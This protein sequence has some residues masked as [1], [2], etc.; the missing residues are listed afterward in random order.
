M[1]AIVASSVKTVYKTAPNQEHFQA[2]VVLGDGRHDLHKQL[3]EA[4]DPTV[5]GGV[6]KTVKYE[7]SEPFY[8]RYLH[9]FV[10]IV[11]SC[12]HSSKDNE[13]KEYE[14]SLSF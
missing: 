2:L 5:V 8:R 12:T 6:L 3:C 11:H 1:Q 13:I 7:D 4:M 14:V 10:R 9:D